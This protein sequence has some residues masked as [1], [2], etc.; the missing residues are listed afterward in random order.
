[1][2]RYLNILIGSMVLIGSLSFSCLYAQEK[3]NQSDK[4]YKSLAIEQSVCK[5]VYVIEFESGDVIYAQEPHMQLPP[6]SMVKMMLLYI[7]FEKIE[8]KEISIDD[9][10][11][12][13]AHASKMGGS[14]V[15][16][17]HNEKFTLRELIQAVIIQSANDAAMAIAEYI[18][19]SDQGF[20]DLMNLKASELDLTDTHFETP[21]GL[22]PGR[23]QKSD[24]SSAHDLAVLGREI[25]M[26]FKEL[27]QWG[28]VE[29]MGFRNGEFIMTNTNHLIGS[30]EGCDGIKTGY[31]REAG[32]CITS[33]A[34]RNGVRVIAVVMAC[35]GSKERFDEAARFLTL[36]FNLYSKKMI[37]EKGEQLNA[38][39]PVIDGKS[40]F[41]KPV[42]ATDLELVLK[43][44]KL[45]NIVKKISLV[46]ELNAPV[47]TGARCGQIEIISDDHVLG[48]VELVANQQVESLSFMGKILRAV[49]LG[50]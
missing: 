24:L 18:G 8:Q 45:D 27:T 7:V 47:E 11:T 25:I 23:D 39:I 41:V 33:T 42:I 3:T 5:S 1:M 19:G 32:F 16:L 43:N 28:K 10:V 35:D 44:D 14:Q 34:E 6:A 36:G 37:V 9:I 30:F 46:K 22:P 49:G 31:H 48:Q 29:K 12:V 21:H 26:N 50:D 38:E 40:L 2:S 17:K 20:V 13:S 4:G 15:Y